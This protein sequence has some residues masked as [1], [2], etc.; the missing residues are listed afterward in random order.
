MSESQ[1]SP[2]RK[3]IEKSPTRKIYL[4]YLYLTKN[5]CLEHIKNSIK[6]TIQKW[7]AQQTNEYRK[8]IAQRMNKE[9]VNEK[10]LNVISCQRNEN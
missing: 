8:G 1:K 6:L 3:W 7:T 10:A 5:L 9:Y 2:L 4:W